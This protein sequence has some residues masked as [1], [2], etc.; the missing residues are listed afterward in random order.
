MENNI[1]MDVKGA[2]YEIVDGIYL[3]QGICHCRALLKTAIEL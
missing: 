1:K 2:G 3:I